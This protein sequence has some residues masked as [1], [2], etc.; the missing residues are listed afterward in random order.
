MF[1][2]FRICG[3]FY[4]DLI[5]LFKIILLLIL[6]LKGGSLFL[7][8]LIVRPTFGQLVKVVEV[9]LIDQL[10]HVQHDSKI[11]IFIY[12]LTDYTSTRIKCINREER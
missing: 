5:A 11:Q 7:R 10:F 2:L 8:V 12:K 9:R 3:G 1:W 6:F 4:W